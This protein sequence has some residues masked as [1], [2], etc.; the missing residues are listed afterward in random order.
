MFV[1][2]GASIPAVSAVGDEWPQW[3]GPN[4]DGVSTET[5]ILTN[6]PAGGPKVVWEAKTGAG[7]ASTWYGQAE[8]N[9]PS[10]LDQ[11]MWLYAPHAVF[12]L[13]VNHTRLENT[14]QTN[15]LSIY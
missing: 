11:P 3:L 13:R 12:T 9:D 6:W 14:R 10:R 5:D 15:D 8:A 4:R 2:L 7:F 1:S